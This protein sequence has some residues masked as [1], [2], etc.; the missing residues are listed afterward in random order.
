MKKSIKSILI[1]LWSIFFIGVTT[2]FSAQVSVDRKNDNHIEP[3]NKSDY[4]QAQYF[5][6]TSTTATSTFAGPL[7]APIF[8]R[9]GQVY[10]VKSY[11][12]IGDGITDDSSAFQA[13]FDAAA[14]VKGTVY[15]PCGIYIINSTTTRANGVN[16]DG[17][18]SV[19]AVL[20]TTRP[21]SIIQVQGGGGRIQNLQLLANNSSSTAI[22]YFAHD[23]SIV[24]EQLNNIFIGGGGGGI[25]GRYGLWFHTDAGFEV[26][27]FRADTVDIY[28]LDI[29]IYIDLPSS[30][31]FT[32]VA[33][34]YGTTGVYNAGGITTYINPWFEGLTNGIIGVRSS[35]NYVLNPK[36]ASVTTLWTSVPGFG[37]TPVFNN[38]T[39]AVS[40]DSENTW[41]SEQTFASTTLFISSSTYSNNV[42]IN[43]KGTTGTV[44]GSIFLDD[45]N[46]MRLQGLGTLPSGNVRISTTDLGNTIRDVITVDGLQNTTIAGDL[47]VSSSTAVSYFAGKVGIKT[48]TPQSIFSIHGNYDND[49][50]GGFLLDATD[51]SDPN[52]YSLR[53]N[54]FVINSGKVGYQFVTTS[55]TG[56]TSTPITFDNVGNVGIGTTSPYAKLSVAGEVVAANFT[57]TTTA[58]STLPNINATTGLKAA[59]YYSSDGTT[60]FT[61]TCTIL[62]LTSITIKNGLITSCQ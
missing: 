45:S 5:T 6:A 36:I 22:E 1:S 25:S 38:I 23:Q 19:G 37:Y 3:Q 56:G 41:L 48:V 49:G 2:V 50:S 40:S 55:S 59:N 8:D 42:P 24:E 47:T 35:F 54:P 57:A 28:G 20:K 11:G 15:V 18:S 44:R 7:Q 29:S 43:W 58:T 61:G 52:K 12:A 53:I 30:Y 26:T 46:I 14:I 9:G 31:L 32:N 33:T 34:E 21:I 39:N 60:G 51:S 62:G 13:T 27:A 4:I 17:C 16:I 10:N